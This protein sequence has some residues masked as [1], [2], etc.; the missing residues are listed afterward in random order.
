M[1]PRIILLVPPMSAKLAGEVDYYSGRID[2]V[3]PDDADQAAAILNARVGSLVEIVFPLPVDPTDTPYDAVEAAATATNGGV[4]IYLVDAFM[5][6]SKGERVK[7]RVV[8]RE[9]GRERRL[10]VPWEHGEPRFDTKTLT[11]CG[12]D[13]DEAY[14]L[15]ARFT[16][17]V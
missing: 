4:Y 7:G 10:D 1:D 13:V 14:G 6:P 12:L 3:L 8:F 16:A 5:E 17:A 15:L 11:T 2:G 9:G